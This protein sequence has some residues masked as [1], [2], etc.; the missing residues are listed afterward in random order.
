MQDYYEILGL[1]PSATA[2]EILRA[3]RRL[4]LIYHPDVNRSPDAAETFQRINSAYQVL[5]D[6]AMRAEYDAR[7]AATRSLPASSRRGQINARRLYFE[8]RVRAAADPRSTWN[9]YNVLGVPAN[10]SD[11]TIARAFHRL[12]RDFYGTGP[13]DPATG[14]ILQEIIDARDVLS[15]PDRRMS[16]D[17]LPAHQQAPGRPLR[18]SP[19]RAASRRGRTGSGSGGRIRPGCLVGLLTLPLVVVYLA[20]RRV[21]TL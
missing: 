10:A 12:Y 9:Y 20:I 6:P 4:A 15:N 1:D 19:G 11:D 17:S 2:G 7:S 16:Y 3:F 14:A 21:S 8:R 5:I 13:D 18:P